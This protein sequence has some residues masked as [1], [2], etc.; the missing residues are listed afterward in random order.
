MLELRYQM[1]KKTE[2]QRLNSLCRDS[3]VLYCSGSIRWL[4]YNFQHIP[5]FMKKMSHEITRAF[6]LFLGKV[7]LI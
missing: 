4:S 1:Q 2:E 6:L 5:F 7:H 3:V